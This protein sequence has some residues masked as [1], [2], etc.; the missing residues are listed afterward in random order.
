MQNTL[1]IISGV[2][3]G[4]GWWFEAGPSPGTALGEVG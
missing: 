1:E 3:E 2:E 4:K